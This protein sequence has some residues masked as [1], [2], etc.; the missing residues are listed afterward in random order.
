M[1]REFFIIKKIQT[2][3]NQVFDASELTKDEL[4]NLRSHFGKN[5]IHVWEVPKISEKQKRGMVKQKAKILSANGVSFNTASA[6]IWELFD[7]LFPTS[8]HKAR[9]TANDHDEHLE[10]E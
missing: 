4:E 8:V 2:G 6:I 9:D 7:S 5:L 1:F 3:C 10:G